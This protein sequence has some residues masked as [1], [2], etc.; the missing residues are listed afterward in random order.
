MTNRRKIAWLCLLLAAPA[1][2]VWGN[3]LNLNSLGSRALSM[4]GAF[5]AVADDFSAV[6]W[7]PAGAAGFRFRTFG[8]YGTDII[9]SGSYRLEL[10]PLTVDATT[11]LKHYLGGLGAYYQPVG[12]GLVAGLA[13]YTPSGLGAAWPGEDFAPVTA[14]RPYNWSSRIGLITVSPVLAWRIDET[15]SVGAAINANFGAFDVQTHAGVVPL[16]AGAGE[17]DLGQY[18]ESLDGFGWGATFGVLVA[19]PGGRY[20]LGL[21]VRTP[22]RV[23]FSGEASISNLLLLDEPDVSDLEREV[24]FPLWI[25]AGAAYRPIDRLLL[26]A[27]VHWT[28]WSSLGRIDGEFA[29]PAWAPLIG[30]AGKDSLLLDW[31]NTAQL[32]VGAEYALTP[33]LALRA[34]YYRDP[35]PAPDRTMNVLLPS[36]DFNVL[37][38]GLGYAL[39]ELRL[40]FGLEYLAGAARTVDFAKTV[41][42]PLWETAM[43]GTY[44]FS[45]WVP[46]VSVSYRF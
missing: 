2:L 25:A 20:R 40:D 46:N 39:D 24:V 36:A 32:R 43:P 34:G 21:T 42:D 7:N 5:A 1:P 28:R 22:S 17:F 14:G 18:K 29:D 15:F 13:V 4:G 12:R 19:P 11:S 37:T 10:L 38:L 27:D 26:S 8:F 23:R 30:L 3:G 45:I 16:P 6:F 44:D 9:P 33:A 41:T 35:S 31:R